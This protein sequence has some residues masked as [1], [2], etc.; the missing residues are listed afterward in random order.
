MPVRTQPLEEPTLNLTP[1]IDVILVLIIFFMVATKF[2]EEERSVDV[3][4]PSI[5]SRNAAMTAPEPKIVNV[6][7]DGRVALGSRSVTLDE[8][9]K[10]LAAARS[11][12]K[13]LNVLIR[14][15]Q[16]ATH[17]QMTAVYDACKQAGIAELAISVK[18]DTKRR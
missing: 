11:Q 4:V 5:S 1:M 17:G 12:Y 2:A 7:R 14:G 18:L 9:K 8:L 10:Q 16:L 6:H 13:R 15:D 3:Q